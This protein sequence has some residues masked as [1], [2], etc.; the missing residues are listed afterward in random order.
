MRAELRKAVR[1]YQVT[2]A[3]PI[4][5]PTAR[6]TTLNAVKTAAGRLLRARAG[7]GWVG[8][9]ASGLQKA[10]DADQDLE[11]RLSAIIIRATGQR[12]SWVASLTG[13]LEALS[14]TSIAPGA[15]ER[16]KRFIGK[17]SQHLEILKSLNVD[18]LAPKRARW[19]D[20]ALPALV[21]ALVPLWRRITQRSCLAVELSGSKRPN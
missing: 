15:D 10:S 20:P 5:T 11:R 9:L 1:Q 2:H 19:P 3:S 8:R 7:G 13:E 14:A 17:W 21:F 4:P 18:A 16:Q 12:V 6:R